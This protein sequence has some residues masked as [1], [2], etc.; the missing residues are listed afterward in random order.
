VQFFEK[1]LI[2]HSNREKAAD[3]TNSSPDNESA[4]QRLV[5]LT[6]GHR[7]YPMEYSLPSYDEDWTVIRT[8][9]NSDKL[10]AIDCEMVLCKDG[11]EALVRV[12]AVDRK[13]KVKIDEIVN[14]QKDIEDYRT[15]ITG[16]KAE[17]LAEATCSLN[18]VQK[19]LKRLL[20]RGAVLTGHSLN[21]DLHALKMDYARVIDTSYIFKYDGTAT[22]RPSL[23][24]LCKSVLNY[25]L[26]EK[27]NPHNCLDDARAVMR[28]VLAR[29]EGKTDGSVAAD[30]E[31]TENTNLIVHRIPADVTVEDLKT[32]IPGKFSLQVKGTKKGKRDTFYT[33]I[34][35][36][37]NVP[38]VAEAFEDLEGD[39]EKD[40]SGR[41][42]KVIRFLLKSGVSGTLCVCV[43][44]NVPLPPKKRSGDEDGD[45]APPSKKWRRD[46]EEEKEREMER[47]KEELKKKD[48]EIKNLGKIIAALAR[49][50]GL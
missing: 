18:D 27:G 33:A 40:S 15:S 44:G 22:R 42:Q 2:S 49:K 32:I 21:N 11:S 5:R 20:S 13:L 3:F 36:F 9:R 19:L 38:D 34:A 28:L 10:I 12:C 48:E 39:L 23:S 26:R 37:E 24:F 16:I 46:D 35:S 25:E 41:P 43:S 47:L 1:V 7:L 6:L 50:Q 4:V 17:D 45:V 14:P 31:E 8:D 30:E 29:L